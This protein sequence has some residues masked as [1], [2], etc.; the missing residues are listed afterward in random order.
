MR[1]FLT[2]RLTQLTIM[3]L[4]LV[5]LALPAAATPVQDEFFLPPGFSVETVIDGLSLP[6]AFD[7]ARDGRIFVAEK[8]GRVRVVE[9]GVLLEEPFIDLSH[10]VNDDQTRGLMGLALHPN[11]PRTPYVYVTYVYE[12]AEAKG[13]PDSGGRVRAWRASK[14]ALLIAMSTSRAASS[15]CSARTARGKTSAIR[16]KAINRPFPARTQQARRFRT[17]CQRKARPMS[18]IL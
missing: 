9:N 11:F 16:M 18:S 10:E 13:H 15:F 6:I 5:S 8:S 1:R 17:V 4:I 3:L 14:P 2:Q 7:V 12:P